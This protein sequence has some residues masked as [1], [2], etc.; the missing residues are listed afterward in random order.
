MDRYNLTKDLG[1][2]SLLYAKHKRLTKVNKDSGIVWFLFDD[3]NGCEALSEAF[4]RREVDVNAREFV[5][6]MRCLK[7]MI[8]N[9]PLSEKTTYSH[10]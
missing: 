7:D 3:K 4:W 6:A 5:D 2:A 8:F 1:E 10:V 9:R